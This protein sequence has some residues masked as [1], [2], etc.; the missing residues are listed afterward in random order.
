MPSRSASAVANASASGR[1]SRHG[2]ARALEAH[3]GVGDRLE[4]VQ[5]ERRD[6]GVCQRGQRRGAARVAHQRSGRG[7]HLGG[8]RDLGVGHAQQDRVAARRAPAAA[9]G[10][11]DLDAGVAKRARE[12]GSNAA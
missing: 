4:R 12:R 10:A 3:T 11:L 1:R 9:Q 8:G 6:A 2:R 5:A 7:H